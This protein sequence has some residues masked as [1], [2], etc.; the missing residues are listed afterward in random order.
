MLY[1]V[2]T[3]GLISPQ[4]FISVAEDTG[5]IVP[6]GR[7]IFADACRQA[8]AW[9]DKG[10]PALQFAVNL[11]AKQFRHQELVEEIRQTLTDQGI[12]RNNFV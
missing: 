11:S 10:Y 9:R 7:W 12:E 6:I 2:I 8:A 4:D 5:L 1:E 3:K